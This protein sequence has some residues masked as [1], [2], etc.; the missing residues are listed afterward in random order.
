ME[1][2]GAAIGGPKEALEGQGWAKFAL[3]STSSNPKAGEAVVRARAAVLIL[4]TAISQ[5]EVR[6][7]GSL[8]SVGLSIDLR[9]RA[10]AAGSAV[11]IR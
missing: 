2:A 4:W 1:R 6:Q 5:G 7:A 10:A 8:Q 9:A 3:A 11:A